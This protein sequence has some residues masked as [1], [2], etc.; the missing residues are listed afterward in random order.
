M[1]KGFHEDM[2]Q[3]S[4]HASEVVK[5]HAQQ[6]LILASYFRNAVLW[7]P[8]HCAANGGWHKVVTLLI[9]AEADIDPT[10]KTKV[11]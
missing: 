11:S 7:T 3:S 8:M 6:T 2:L 4:M 1:G 10:D 9:E 5:D